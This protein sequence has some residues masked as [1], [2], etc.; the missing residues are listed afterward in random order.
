MNAIDMKKLIDSLSQDIDFEYRGIQGT[1]CPFSRNDISLCYSEEEI[2]VDSV[3]AAMTTPF[4][5]GKSLAEICDEI[6]L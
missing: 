1:I 6:I 4:V 3:E 5:D 2:T